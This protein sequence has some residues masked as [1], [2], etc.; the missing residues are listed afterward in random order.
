VKTQQL[1]GWRP[2]QIG[3]LADIEKGSYFKNK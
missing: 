3:L 1:L 2:T